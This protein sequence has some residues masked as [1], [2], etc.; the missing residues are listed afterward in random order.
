MTGIA[1]CGIGDWAGPAHWSIRFVDDWD[2]F[3]FYL[4]HATK[5]EPSSPRDMWQ[6]NANKGKRP[7]AGPR[8]DSYNK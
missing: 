8:P 1:N 2:I 7:A 6:S 3:Y 5:Q 4:I